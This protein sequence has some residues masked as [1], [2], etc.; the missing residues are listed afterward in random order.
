MGAAAAPRAALARGWKVVALPGSA[1][2]SCLRLTYGR[3]GA[4]RVLPRVVSR[5][6]GAPHAA[7]LVSTKALGE[8]HTRITTGIGT[9]E[10]GQRATRGGASVGMVYPRRG[11]PAR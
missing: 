3:T 7:Q 8:V 2:L 10:V 5:A 4:V 6:S 11:G 9:P 1:V